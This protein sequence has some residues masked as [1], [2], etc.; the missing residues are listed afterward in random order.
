MCYDASS[1]DD[2]IVTYGN[3]TKNSATTAYPNSV[4]YGNRFGN[5][6]ACYTLFGIE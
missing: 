4:A 2:T 6:G 3:A 1:A 5:Q